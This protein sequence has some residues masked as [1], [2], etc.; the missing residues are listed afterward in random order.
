M[1]EKGQEGAGFRLIIEAVIVIL[2]LV[3][4]LGVVS[5][6]DQW[7]WMV[8][9]RRLFEGFKTALNTPDGSIVVQN[10]LVLK[11]GSMY[12]NRAFASSVAGIDAECIEIDAVD[13]AAFT[14]TND[15][16][17]EINTLIETDVFFRCLPKYDCPTFCTISFGKELTQE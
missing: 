17:I 6:I 16:V 14:V 4:I 13:S 11:D 1:N 3:I 15:K 7:R 5:Q 10:A 12:S 2:I 9:E 8:S